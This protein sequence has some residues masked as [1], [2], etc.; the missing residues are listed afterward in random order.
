MLLHY[1]QNQIQVHVCIPQQ[2][3][4]YYSSKS[5][6]LKSVFDQ[7]GVWLDRPYF[8]QRK[9]FPSLHTFNSIQS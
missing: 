1:K 9:Q 3:A 7:D 4:N 2:L 5:F 6:I 8:V